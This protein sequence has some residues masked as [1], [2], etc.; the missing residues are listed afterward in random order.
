M[1]K[2][3]YFKL[4]FWSYYRIWRLQFLICRQSQTGYFLIAKE[5]VLHKVATIVKSQECN[6]IL[7]QPWCSSTFSFRSE[8]AK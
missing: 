7:R 5:E 6:I 8:K 2:E 1:S 3:L 4:L